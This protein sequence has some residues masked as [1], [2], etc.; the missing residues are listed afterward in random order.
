[1][2]GARPRAQWA[3]VPLSE[4]ILVAKPG[5]ACG[6]RDPEG[7]VQLRMNNIGTRGTMVWNDLTRIPTSPEQIAD[8]RLEPDDVL[9]NNTNSVELVGKSALFTGFREPVVYSNHFTRLRVRVDRCKPAFLAAWLQHQWSMRTFSNLCNRWIG[10]SAVKKEKLFSLRIPLPPVPEQERLASLL[11]DQMAVIERTRAA[12]EEELAT[13]G[14]LPAA[15][16][17]RAFNGEM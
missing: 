2:N 14:L 13:I 17:R 11:A 4:V 15:I 1:M 3:S 12:A 9:F 5:F 7:T 10:Q 6:V 8:Y 16:L